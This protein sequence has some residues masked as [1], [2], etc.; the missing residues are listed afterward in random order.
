MTGPEQGDLFSGQL[1]DGSALAEAE[2]LF[3]V[4]EHV[5]CYTETHGWRVGQVLEVGRG[6]YRLQFPLARPVWAQ[7]QRLRAVPMSH[8]AAA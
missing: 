7:A 4:G 6:E 1:F 2:A 5:W 8:G 3:H